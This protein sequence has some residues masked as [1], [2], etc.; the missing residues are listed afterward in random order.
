[1]AINTLSP[2]TTTTPTFREQVG[3]DPED[4]SPQYQN[5]YIFTIDTLSWGEVDGDTVVSNPDPDRTYIE[6]EVEF[7][8]TQF[9]NGVNG[10]NDNQV[11]SYIQDRFDVF[12]DNFD[13]A[14]AANLQDEVNA[15]LN[16]QFGQLDHIQIRGTIEEWLET[17]ADGTGSLYVHFHASY[18]TNPP[19]WEQPGIRVRFGGYSSHWSLDSSFTQ[20]SN[21]IEDVEF[22]PQERWVAY[23]SRD[24]NIFVHD[25][26]SWG[27]TQTLTQ[28]GAV[29]ELGAN[30]DGSL[31]ASTDN[32]GECVVYNTSDWS[33]AQTFTDADTNYG[34]S[35]AFSP[36]DAY[37]AY[38][39]ASPG[40]QVRNTSDWSVEATLTD[41]T[42]TSRGATWTDSYLATGSSDSNAYVYDWTWT[43]QQTITV[44]GSLVEDIDF[45]DDVSWMTVASDD[46][47][48]YIIDTSDWSTHTTISEGAAVQDSAFWSDR[49]V[50]YS[51]QNAG[52]ESHEYDPVNGWP[53]DNSFTEPASRSYVAVF[54]YDGKY[55]AAADYGSP[56]NVHIYDT[57]PTTVSGTFYADGTATGGATVTAFNDTQGTVQGTTQT[58]ADGT[59][60]ISFPTGDEGHF[61]VEYTDADGNEYKAESK[62]FIVPE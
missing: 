4:G 28:N 26:G 7:H 34:R 17:T 31:L 54:S 59:F 16:E 38:A 49:F 56:Y 47:N 13:Q 52:N 18:V 15:I 44:A 5:Y 46:G 10:R 32:S 20:A 2:S 29:M 24:N 48:L 27:H 51:H 33:V 12:P 58:N 8:L 25:Y 43:L 39:E 1:M 45:S 62:P 9:G 21:T 55:F 19:G 14:D 41:M 40:L 37:L 60:S 61:L 11:V 22:D 3:T 42:N 6:A 35:C 23:G 36:D 50:T 53:H 57:P 30:S